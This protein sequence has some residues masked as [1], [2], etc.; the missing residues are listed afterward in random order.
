METAGEKVTVCH[1]E[2]VSLVKVAVAS[3]VPVLVQR[4]PI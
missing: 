1:P 3:S 2:A 4:L